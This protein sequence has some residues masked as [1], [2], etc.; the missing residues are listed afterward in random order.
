MAYVVM[1]HKYIR[2]HGVASSVGIGL[3][4]GSADA[5]GTR[6]SG[7]TCGW[8]CALEMCMGCGQRHVRGGVGRNMCVR[9]WAETC[10]W[11]C[12]QRHVHGGVG[13]EELIFEGTKM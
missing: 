13:R 12:G 6:Q 8:T 4:G 5:C 1:K 3:V 10:A 9:V 7:R 11:G 2:T